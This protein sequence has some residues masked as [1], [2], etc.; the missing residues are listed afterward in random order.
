MRIGQV[1]KIV[2]K[3]IAETTANNV[4]SQLM[5]KLP[6]RNLIFGGSY[7]SPE[8]LQLIRRGVRCNDG[9][10][11]PILL[12][13]LGVFDEK[14]RR[15]EFAHFSLPYLKTFRSFKPCDVKR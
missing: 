6:L 13:N 14:F 8:S 12:F 4:G 7:K 11:R 2:E 10:D 1:F 5:P 9:N 3:I 15:K